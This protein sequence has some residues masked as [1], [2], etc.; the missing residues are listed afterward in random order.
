MNPLVHINISHG[1]HREK[2]SR[3]AFEIAEEV[4]RDLSR[5]AELSSDPMSRFLSG[6]SGMNDHDELCKRRKDFANHIAN[7]VSNEVLKILGSNDVMDGYKRSEFPSPSQ[8]LEL[9]EL[10]LGPMVDHNKKVDRQTKDSDVIF[11]AI[12]TGNFNNYN[13]A[14]FA[15][16]MLYVPD[17]SYSREGI[18][19]ALGRLKTHYSKGS[20]L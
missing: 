8:S 12:S 11:T 13:D 14:E 7:K 6:M 3:I 5:S 18:S 15:V 4:M 19:H 16:I 9:D 17:R 1:F 10:F 20:D 2:N